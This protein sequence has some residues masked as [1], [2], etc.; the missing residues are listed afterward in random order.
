MEVLSFVGGSLLSATFDLLLKKL[1]GYLTD[2]LRN[3]KEEVRAQM[4]SWKTLLPKIIIVIQHAEENQVANQFV[5][6]C[7]DDLRNLAYDMEDLLEEFVID[8]KR[9]KLITKSKASI[10]KG[11]KVKSSLK[12]LFR[13]KAKPN[14]E[15]N[16]MVNHLNVRLQHFEKEMHTFG[17]IN[18]T[19]KAED[20]SCKV[21]AERLPESSLLEDKVIGRDGDKDAI[22]QRLLKDGGNPEQDFVI[23]IVGMGGLGK[24]TL[25]RHIY[26]DKNLEGRFL[27]VLDDVW[28]EKYGPWDVLKRPFMS[29]ALG[30]KI[31][32]TTRNK[33]VGM[34]MRGDDRVYNLELLQDAA[35][36]P[37]FT[38]HALGK[39]NFDAHPYLQDVGEKL[40]KRCKRL[41]LALKTVGGV[42]RGKLHR[43]EWEN[44]L[45]SD[46]WSSSEDRSEILPALRLSYNH[47]PSHLKR[48]F[49][50]C[51]LFPKDYEFD[52]MELV[53]LW[54][55][56]GLLQQQSHEKKQMEE[57]IGHQYFD[58]LFLR[59]LFQR[60]SGDESRFVMHDLINDLALDVAGKIYC[61]LERSMGDE[62][63]EKARHLSFTPHKY[64]I[65]ERFT[66]L[67]KLKHLRTF[68]PLKALNK[69]IQ[70]YLSK[71]ILHEFLP[72]LN[73]LRVLSLH[74]YQISELPESF[75]N[76]KHIR[77]LPITIGNL[78][79]L[80]HL[81][82]TDTYSLKEMPSGIG[83][84]KNL[85]TLSKFIVGKA[86]GMM[87]RLS[88]LKNLSQ[89][90]G[91]L[92]ILDLQNVLDVQ[93]AREANLDKIHG[94]EELDLEWLALDNDRDES[95]LEMQVL[96]WLNPHSNLKSLKI[97]CY[98]GENFP[99]WVCDPSLF[100]NLSSMK[101]SRCERCTLL[102]SIGLLPVL[103]ELIIE[104]MD[105]IEA[106]SFEFY[107]QHGS[108]PS[109]AELVFRRM[110]N[111]KEWTSP[112]KS[113]GE[114]PC[115]HKLVIEN[116]PKL[117]GQ[118]PSNL[119]SL[120]ELDV[121]RCNGKLLKS[122][123]DVPSLT[124]LRIEQIS[125]LTCLP[126]SMSLP[127]LKE[128][129][130]RD[131]NGVLLKSMVDLTSL[132]NLEIEQI[133]ELT[134]L[135]ESF[136]QS[137]TALETLDITYCNDLTCLWED[138]TE[139]EQS[140]LPF[141]LKHLSLRYCEALESLPDAMMMRMDGSS[142]SNTSMLMSRLERLEICDCDSLKSFPRG[143]LP[144]SLKYLIIEKCEGLESLPDVDGD[145]NS[146]NLHLEIMNIPSSHSSQGSCLQVPAFLKKSRICDGG[147]WL[148][149]F[150]E[151]MLQH[152]RRIQSIEIECCKI[153]KSLPSLNCI[154][155]LVKLYIYSCKTLESLPEELGLCTPN[156]KIL[157]IR[158]CKNFKSLPNT[159]YQL[160]SFRRLTMLLC[161]AIEFIL[162]GGLP[163]NLTKLQLEECKNLKRLPN[164]MFQ[165]TS[166]QRLRIPGGALTMGLQNLT[167]LLCLTIEQ[168]LPLDIVLPCSLISLEIKN[169]ENLESI[170]S[171]LFQNLSSLKHL[172]IT[173]C[174]NL[175][176]LPGEAFPPSLGLLYINRCPHLKR[177]R[178]EAK[179]DCWT[180]TWSIPC[181]RI[182]EDENDWMSE[183]ATI[184]C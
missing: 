8:A 84:L 137:L 172:W 147:E 10:N 3:S 167:S 117:L 152:C 106:I 77:K 110:P 16:S 47:L 165:L 7:L 51:A 62:K 27:L 144:T 132:T 9:F 6:S 72:T 111:W 61:N 161:P 184:N 45:N 14:Q 126:M 175:Q 118:L 114:F 83:N 75:Q 100:F 85:V 145:Y 48:C 102:P 113:A 21:A 24:T 29:G 174:Q 127:S 65:L 22:L 66:V 93:E 63:L 158:W 49:A 103:K 180:L 142:S 133:S 104:G 33:N 52:K 64:E 151:R 112:T 150:P 38:Q 17:L 159:M 73:R 71:R 70:F 42:L 13:F 34:I 58:E 101:L 18:L 2:Q 15:I 1:N 129:S 121:R 57:D 44:V 26:N 53:L 115:L 154:S 23:P 82:I 36:L 138:G 12:N 94:L 5:K 120:K 125:E 40:I 164:T 128:L 43:D 166:L 30:S 134:C 95:I 78:I 124:Y 56:E 59:S 54:M 91:R 148:E 179:G 173:D 28:N 155:S 32:V 168:K 131:C 153:L 163:P 81:D 169:E 123:G 107:G 160:K 39:E 171:W 157:E 183:L 141:N 122:M 176:S 162:D 140:L 119:S 156:L 69:H 37:L 88:D 146:S 46:I 178:F 136:T 182:C 130:I 35:C 96:S 92:S 50:Y 149:S 143:K 11:Q 109:L 98:G 87:T 97:S 177:Q 80:H 170:P 89:L 19:M 116:C 139:I 68:L 86:I 74:H 20:K 135:P 25:S 41:P 60:S 90:R 181:I 31:I 99:P 67:D 55:A 76:L 4:E 105:S 108:F 79:D